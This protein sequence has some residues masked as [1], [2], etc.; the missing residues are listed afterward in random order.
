MCRVLPTIPGS[1]RRWGYRN[2]LSCQ[3]RASMRGK[4][5]S[6]TEASEMIPLIRRII[7]NVRSRQRLANRKEDLARQ[8]GE[9]SPARRDELLQAVRKLRQELKGYITEL[10]QLGCFLRDPEAGI[11]E[12]YGELE[13]EIVYFTWQPGHEAFLYWHRLD[14]P[15]VRRQP[16]P[17]VDLP[18][19]HEAAE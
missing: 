11:V 9:E 8:V 17:G 7:V 3:N 13:G 6:P 15:Y 12:C 18:K 5:F 19:A 2:R 16:L 4:I 10:E 14:D 1:L